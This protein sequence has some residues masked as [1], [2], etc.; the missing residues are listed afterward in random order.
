MVNDKP[1]NE[2]ENSGSQD[3]GSDE[4]SLLALANNSYQRKNFTEAL[5]YLSML[6]ANF[7]DKPE[8]FSGMAIIQKKLGYYQEAEKN[9]KKAI[10]INPNL[11]EGYYNLGILT[12]EQNNIDEAITYF[13]KS[14]EVKP[15]VYLSY[16]NLGNAYR[17][18]NEF[19]L[20]ADC[21]HK[22]IELKKDFD[23]AHYNLGVV[24]EKRRELTKAI[25][26]YKSAIRYNPK[27]LNA[28]WNLALLYLQLGNFPKGWP[29][30][31]VRKE[32]NKSAKRTFSKPALTMESV[33]GKKIL[34]YCEQGLGDSIQFARYLKILKAC[35]AYIIFECKPQLTWLFKNFNG[36]DELISE[37]DYKEMNIGYD[38]NIS[39]LSL[40]LYFNTVLETI[41]SEVPY[42]KANPDQVHKWEAKIKNEKYIN[43]GI[44]WSG[45]GANI[46]GKDRSCSL[47]DFSPLFS[48]NGIKLYSIQKSENGDEILNSKFPVINFDN[49][50][51]VPFQDTAAIIENLDLVISID[52]SI[53]HLAGAIG[54]PVWTLLPYYSDW[55]WL[56]D[57][58]GTPWY[59]TM[60]LFRQSEPGN[61]NNVFGAVADEIK[62]ILILKAENT[63]LI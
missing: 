7:P 61:W 43:I 17:E 24:C 19:N 23:D 6:T 1:L 29:K 2:Q 20:S 55:R 46:T 37:Y 33:N 34:V 14:L 54:K 49:L 13:W 41:P 3:F 31:E 59:P 38:Y 26:C 25:E 22:A 12:Y 48:I 15:N 5:H 47:K 44:A 32:R 10:E 45:A 35:G 21:Y 62:R 58:K 28:Q 9:Y 8:Y 57:R 4:S 60:K 51:S 50:D 18:R 53:A 42:L 40:P 52:T 36:I 63:S 39:L 30:Y 11:F 27:N 16:Y 56:L